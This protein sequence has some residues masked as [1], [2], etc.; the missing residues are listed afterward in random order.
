MMKWHHVG[1][2]VQDLKKSEKF[3]REVFGFLI[4]QRLELVGEK[5]TF[6][7]RDSIRIELILSEETEEYHKDNI[8]MS[9]E[10]NDL[11][12]WII[13]TQGYGIIPTEGPIK[14]Q[15]GWSTVFYEGPDQEL[16]ELIEIANDT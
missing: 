4:E 14:L 10:I 12:D 15:N 7:I 13:H 2:Q 1:I 5:I 3:Y 11:N 8:H 16:I 9:W 6:L